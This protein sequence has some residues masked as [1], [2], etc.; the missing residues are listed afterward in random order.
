MLQTVLYCKKISLLIFGVLLLLIFLEVSLRL[1]GFAWS[2]FQ[3]YRNLQSIKQKGTY[4]IMCLGEST[5]AGG[6][7]SYPSQLEVIL[8]KTVAGIK[9]SVINKGVI[10]TKTSDILVNL[11]SYLNKYKPDIVI[12]M[13]GI[14]DGGTCILRNNNAQPEKIACS[15]RIYNLAKLLWLKG[16]V[17]FKEIQPSHSTVQDS[18]PQKKQYLGTEKISV[19]AKEQKP[20]NIEGYIKLAQHY[21]Q[22]GEYYKAERMFK[23]AIEFSPK[24]DG[25]CFAFG[26]YYLQQGENQKSEEYFKKTIGLNPKHDGAYVHLGWIYIEQ[27]KLV[28]GEELL[29][30][31]IG[32]NK[33]NSCAYFELGRCYML[34]NKYE[35]AEELIQKSIKINPHQ[36]YAY[37]VLGLSY[38]R[39]NKFASAEE[40]FKKAIEVNPNNTHIYAHLILL[41][42][43]MGNY[44]SANEYFV[45]L[46]R[47]RTK[48]YNPNTVY[49]YLKVKKILETRGIRLVCVQYPMI[50]IEPLRNIFAG[51]EGIIFVDNEKIFKE[52]VK[53]ENLK[54]YFVDMFA[55]NFGHCTE[56][57][58]RLLA[59]N[60]ARVI[61]KDVFNKK[62]KLL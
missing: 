32:L 53:G 16:T 13:M 5:T 7:Y 49:N 25:T 33:N 55:G 14:N 62:A 11:E 4:R 6:E 57:G 42:E 59:E 54:E 34:Q 39:Q 37:F 28:Q 30:K 10:G 23:D 40:L 46:D 44:N 26:E 21:Q 2:F 18:Y 51:Q 31:A 61:L 43:E 29:K 27:N 22:Q 41:Y 36:E 38:V 24:H 12:T 47:L 35:L 20:E 56:K 52:V 58:N 1:C 50:D 45:R 19:D 9:I 17:K 48:F 8:N 60:I 3:E 15:L